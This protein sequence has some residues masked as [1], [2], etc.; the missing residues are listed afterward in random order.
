MS[1]TLITAPLFVLLI[2]GFAL[3]LVNIAEEVSAKSLSFASDMNSALD[4]AFEGRL[5]S[6]CSP[7]LLEYDFKSDLTEYQ[8]YNKEFLQNLSSDERFANA[9]VIEQNGKTIIILANK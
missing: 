9:Q 8:D 1:S 3:G 4:C 6:E 5:L 2:S 7:S